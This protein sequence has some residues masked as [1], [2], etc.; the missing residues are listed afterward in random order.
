MAR[1]DGTRGK[2]R[3]EAD[4]AAPGAKRRR[5]VRDVAA[6]NSKAG[7]KRAEIEEARLRVEMADKAEAEWPGLDTATFSAA[8]AGWVE[9]HEGDWS[10]KTTKE[11]RYALRRYILPIIGSTPL[12]ALTP[13]QIESLYGSWSAHGYA[14]S[15]RR[16]WHGIV[17]SI[18]AD[19]VRLGEMRG[20]SPMERVEAAGGK[21]DE[22]PILTPD[23]VRRIIAATPSAL[24]RAFFELAAQTGARRGTLVALRWRDVDLDAGKISYVRAAAEGG[25]GQVLKTNKG[26]KAYA[27]TIVGRALEA[28]R[29]ARAE[30]LETA[31]ALGLAADFG[32][33]FV[34]SRDGGEHSWNVSWPTHAFASAAETAKA[35]ATLHDLRHFAATT[36]LSNGVPVR[37]VADRLGCTEANVIRTYSHRVASPEDA[38]A[39]ELLAAAIG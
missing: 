11:T 3:I 13:A 21:A 23:A 35:T 37:I 34:F 18:F 15:T 26:G 16:R 19:S 32:A 33:L 29:S 28:L 39:A 9:R 8:A 24:T 17:A 27:V 31:M 4:V 22:R 12:D 25:D 7:R 5:V 14:A 30:A 36:M 1:W 38:R 10:P 6:P 2:W 20:P